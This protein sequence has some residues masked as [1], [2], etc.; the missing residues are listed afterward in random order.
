M[1]RKK[2]TVQD[3]LFKAELRSFLEHSLVKQ[4]FAGVDVLATS[5]QTAVHVYVSQTDEISGDNEHRLRELASLIRKRFNYT[6]DSFELMSKKV[7]NRGLSA[8]VQAESLKFSL[9]SGLP[10]RMAANRVIRLTMKQG[11]KGIE[12]AVSGKLRQQRAKTMKF[13]DGY[14]ISTGRPKQLF[15]DEAIRHVL[16]KQGVLGIKVKIMLPHDPEGRLGPKNPMPDVVVILEPKKDQLD[17]D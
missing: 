11:A 5:T 16:M 17:S 12:I 9:V 15:I 2:K 6:R 13:K 10:V 14:L 7:P 1:N 8:A 4:Q 3:G